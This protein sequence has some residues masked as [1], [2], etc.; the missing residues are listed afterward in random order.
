[1]RFRV[2]VSLVLILLIIAGCNGVPPQQIILVVTAT[3]TP[4][5]TSE[6]TAETTAT[7]I[8]PTTEV[9][10][11]ATIAPTTPPEVTVEA[12]TA[13]VEATPQVVDP[14]AVTPPPVTATTLPSITPEPG[15]P[16]RTPLPPNFP[17]PVTADIQVAEQLFE[18]GRM[19]WLQPTNEIWVLVVT[20]EGRGTWSVYQD[21][22]AEGVDPAN[23]PSLMPPEG[24]LQ[25]ERGFG[26][27][28]REA[29]TVRDQLGWAVTPEFGYVSRY[30]YHAGGSVDA[31]GVYTAGP[32]YHVVYSLYG[33]QFRFNEVDGTWQLG[34]G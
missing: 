8:E 5:V 27:L 32:G 1:M 13:P 31:A 34:G 18:G 24:R 33:E 12:T 19:F 6:A 16:S 11:S 20:D 22:W 10:P 21:N 9:P 15:T 3:H 30:E 28:W 4:E 7:V 29:S 14:A 23:D 26:K 17:T 25:P 2:V